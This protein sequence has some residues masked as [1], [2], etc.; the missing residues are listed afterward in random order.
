M[1]KMNKKHKNRNKEYPDISQFGL[2]VR[3]CSFIFIIVVEIKKILN[4]GGCVCR[5][6]SNTDI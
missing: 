4:F 6:N 2:I 1:F 3:K 5:T